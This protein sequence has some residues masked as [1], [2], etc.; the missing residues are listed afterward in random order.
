[1]GRGVQGGTKGVWVRSGER[2]EQHL[3]ALLNT[4]VIALGLPPIP[5]HASI[6][7]QPLPS[8]SPATRLLPSTSKTPEHS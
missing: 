5:G 2:S 1:M 8:T 4:F 3:M 6:P 7:S